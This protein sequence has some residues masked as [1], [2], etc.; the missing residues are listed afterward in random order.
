MCVGGVCLGILTFQTLKSCSGNFCMVLTGGGR[1]C[2]RSVLRPT[3]QLLLMCL[4]V[5]GT[6]HFWKKSSLQWLTWKPVFA[7]VSSTLTA[8][9][10]PRCGMES[11]E[12]WNSA[13]KTASSSRFLMAITACYLSFHKAGLTVIRVVGVL[14]KQPLSFLIFFLMKLMST[15][16]RVNKEDT[17]L[18][19]VRMFII[20]W[21]VLSERAGAIES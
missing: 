15:P 18:P 12:L 10:C 5:F 17:S 16:L 9:P 20:S 4:C 11:E 13:L 8:S 19:N 6:K 1:M 14:V 21:F 3:I 7:E 2:G